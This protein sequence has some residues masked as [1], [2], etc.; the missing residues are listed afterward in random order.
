MCDLLAIAVQTSPIY[1]KGYDRLR[2][3][4]HILIEP[5]IFFIIHAI[6]VDVA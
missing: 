6:G 1:M 3:S 2:T 4:E 5:I